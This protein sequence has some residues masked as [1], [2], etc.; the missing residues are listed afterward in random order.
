MIAST[1][2]LVSPIPLDREGTTADPEAKVLLEGHGANEQ[3]RGYQWF[4]DV[5]VKVT[6]SEI[7]EFLIPLPA[8]FRILPIL[9]KTK[10]S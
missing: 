6:A 10:N 5:N 2:D 4:S 7:S 9:R 3:L 1:D 8:T